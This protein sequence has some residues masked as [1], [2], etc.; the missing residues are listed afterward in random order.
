MQAF[1]DVLWSDVTALAKFALPMLLLSL[2]TSALGAL[3]GAVGYS[4]GSWT[5]LARVIVRGA[6]V[7]S[8]AIVVLGMLLEYTFRLEGL[9]GARSAL[10]E[11]TTAPLWGAAVA[12][13]FGAGFFAARRYAPF[14]FG[15]APVQRRFTLLQLFA[16]QLVIGLFFGWW[17]FTRRD[18][19]GR[20][21]VEL[22]WE[23]RDREA[24]AIFTPLGYEVDTYENNELGLVA[25]RRNGL[26]QDDSLPIV[27]RHD[28]LTHLR[29]E[30]D[31]ISDAG[32][33]QLAPAKRLREF[34]LCAPK[35]T[36][37]GIHAMCQ[38]PR[39]RYL[40]VESPH[41]TAASLNSLAKVKSLRY[42]ALTTGKIT[43]EQEAVFRK[44]R[45]DID[46]R[47]PN[48]ARLLR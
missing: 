26:P 10:R 11:H 27:G 46:L 17:V 6:I 2:P 23:L 22:E 38:L 32:L 47:L 25:W 30:S 48:S 7:G 14:L 42:L 34:Y 35:V 13:A 18:E 5:R 39:L 40:I 24:K 43:P 9:R 20:R 1:W 3:L 15:S 19:I 16:A 41:L 31:A 21:H 44:A 29:I 36:D 12:S 37:E 4:L 33:A 8:L 45:P 28:S